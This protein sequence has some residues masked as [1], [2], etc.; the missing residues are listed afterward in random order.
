MGE[1]RSSLRKLKAKPNCDELHKELK[2][3][4]SDSESDWGI[5]NDELEIKKNDKGMVSNGTI[6]FNTGNFDL[7]LVDDHLKFIYK[8]RQLSP[9]NMYLSADLEI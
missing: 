1:V 8:D 3:A 7:P 2:K 4:I 5:I 6:N 9:I